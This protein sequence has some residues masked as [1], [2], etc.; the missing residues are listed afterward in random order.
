MASG[1]AIYLWNRTTGALYLWEEFTATDNQDGMTTSIS[2]KQYKIAAK[3]NKGASLT[4]EAADFTGD[5]VPDLWAVGVD[6][7]VCPHVVTGPSTRREAEIE[8]GRPQTLR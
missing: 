8:P 5:G 2:Y 4:L 7:T 3:W 1:T 6:G